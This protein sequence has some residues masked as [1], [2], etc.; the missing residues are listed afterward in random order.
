M[1]R[2][3]YVYNYTHLKKDKNFVYPMYKRINIQ[4]NNGI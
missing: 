1:N 4:T 3:T 2:D